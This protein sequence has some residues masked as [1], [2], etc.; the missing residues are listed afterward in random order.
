MMPDNLGST[1]AP[2][3]LRPPEGDD[4]E[5]V[6]AAVCQ[7]IWDHDMAFPRD[8]TFAIAQAALTA[9]NLPARLQAA[10][11]EERERCAKV[12]EGYPRTVSVIPLSTPNALSAPWRIAQAIRS[13]P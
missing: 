10:R 4:V 2:R 7:W 5:A 1:E 3:T 12:A 11:E 6:E 13:A 9:L 8:Y